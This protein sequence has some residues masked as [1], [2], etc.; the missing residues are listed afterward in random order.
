[1]QKEKPLFEGIPNY[2]KTVEF[3]RNCLIEA[4]Q[5]PQRRFAA[6]SRPSP[7]LPRRDPPDGPGSDNMAQHLP[8]A[9][10]DEVG[11]TICN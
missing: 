11:L 7:P 3:I 5:A 4:N 6:A 9:D 1:M 2:G 8:P 10:G